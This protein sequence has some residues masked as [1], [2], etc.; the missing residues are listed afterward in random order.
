MVTIDDNAFYLLFGSKSTKKSLQSLFYLGVAG[1]DFR[2][3]L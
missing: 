2:E 1:F 3:T